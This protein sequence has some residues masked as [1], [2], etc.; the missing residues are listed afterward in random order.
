MRGARHS[1]MRSIMAVALLTATVPGPAAAA[2]AMLRIEPVDVKVL[3][4]AEFTIRIVQDASV[5]TSGAQAT[6]EFDPKILHIA[7]V[8]PGAAYADAA[9]FLPTDMAA[10]VESANQTGKLVQVALAFTPPGSVPA[11]PAAFLVVRFRAVGCGISPLKLPSGG[12]RDA[13]M[14]DGRADSYGVE[15][16]P[17]MTVAGS[18]TT[19]VAAGDVTSTSDEPTPVASAGAGVLVGLVAAG[20]GLLVVMVGGLARRSRR[21]PQP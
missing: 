15:V 4:G 17:L 16:A 10:D 2:D 12:P 18:V 6:L 9:L 19:C 8:T 5:A 11:G 20:A 14:I 21:R 7:S 3:E 1:V 13:Q